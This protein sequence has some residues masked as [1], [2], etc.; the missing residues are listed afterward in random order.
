M[1]RVR[2]P[3]ETRNFSLFHIGQTISGAHP[4]SYLVGAE[5]LFHK[6]RRSRCEI[7][8]S[9]LSSTEVKNGEDV[10]PLSLGF[11]GILNLN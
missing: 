1:S 8:R 3:T 7:D 2:F 5:A 10:P 4:T 9:P 11:N 6:L